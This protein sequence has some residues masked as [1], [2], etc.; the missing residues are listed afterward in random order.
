MPDLDGPLIILDRDNHPVSVVE[1][2]GLLG[3]FGF[4]HPHDAIWLANGDIMVC[5]WNP[6]R[7]AYWRRLG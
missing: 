2:G 3:Q 5:T 6:G 1:V 4:R 7:L